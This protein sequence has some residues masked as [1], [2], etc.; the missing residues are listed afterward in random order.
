MPLPRHFGGSEFRQS[1][2]RDKINGE[3][4][5]RGVY[6]VYRQDFREKKVKA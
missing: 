5:F 1:R 2:R 6:R 3:H 4:H